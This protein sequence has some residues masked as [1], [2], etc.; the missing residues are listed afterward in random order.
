VIRIAIAACLVSAS[1]AGAQEKNFVA[2]L[3]YPQIRG[4][5]VITLPTKNGPW[6]LVAP[7]KSLIAE[8][9]QPALKDGYSF[10]YGNCRVDGVLRQDLIAMVRHAA[11]KQ[12]SRDVSSIWIADPAAKKFV[13]RDPRG[14][15]CK[16]ERYGV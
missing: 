13:R 8:M 1:A 9:K 16:N 5:A 14:V 3:I 7:D 11:N 10:N 2:W 6:R 12:W 15:D 4:S